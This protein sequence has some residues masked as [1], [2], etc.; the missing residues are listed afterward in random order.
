M[1]QPEGMEESSADLYLDS[2]SL[3]RI[4]QPVPFSIKG[5][6]KPWSFYRGINDTLLFSANQWLQSSFKRNNVRS[7]AISLMLLD[8]NR[9]AELYWSPASDNV[10]SLK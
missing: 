6:S 2:T 10:K 7:W 8:S 1:L 4:I 5:K 9:V 3:L